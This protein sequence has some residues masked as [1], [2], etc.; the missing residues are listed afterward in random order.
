[1]FSEPA[2]NRDDLPGKK[3]AK[4]FFS[5]FGH[6]A[7]IRGEDFTQVDGDLE[8]GRSFNSEVRH[9][10]WKGRNYIVCP[11]E[12]KEPKV[13]V[14]FR[15]SGKPDRVPADI[16]LSLSPDWKNC[17][18]IWTDDVR[19]FPEE[20]VYVKDR[21]DDDIDWVRR[22]GFLYVTAFHRDGDKMLWEPCLD[23]CYWA[24]KD[25]EYPAPSHIKTLT[26]L[27]CQASLRSL[28]HLR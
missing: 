21:G 19:H 15:K 28:A 11:L 6:T 10:V 23:H 24:L 16:Q 7:V 20:V 14:L 1:M 18:F 17:V 3:Q 25:G 4:D 26:Y 22:P 5:Q 8:D 13:H 9:N 2:Y 27:N 12:D